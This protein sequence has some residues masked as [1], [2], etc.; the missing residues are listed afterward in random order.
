MKKIFA[1]I[2][3]TLAI[4]NNSMSYDNKTA[5]RDFNTAIV[6]KFKS[7]A[8]EWTEFK[9]YNF[10][11]D[12]V[13]LTG[14]AV[15]ESGYLIV[16]TE[17]RSYTI[18][19]WIKEGGY[20]ADEPEAQAAYRHFYDPVSNDGKTHLTD[21]NMA[22]AQ[23]NPSVDAV[24]WHFMG[25]DVNGNNEWSWHVAKDYMGKA[26]TSSDEKFRNLYLAK[27]LRALGEVLHNTADM[28]CTPHV[29]N[30]AHGGFGLGGSDPYEGGFQPAWIASYAG[31]SCD[32]TL[33]SQFIAAASA[34]EVNR[35]LARFTNKYFFSDETI[36]GNGVETYNSRNGKKDFANPKLDKLAYEAESFNYNYNFPSGRKVQMCNDQSVLL[37]F[38]TS[39]YRSYPRV[40]LKNVE[41]QASE[42][43]PAILEA[44]IHVM[45]HFFPV[46]SV[47]LEIKIQEKI[48]DGT[49]KHTATDEYPN[50]L[51]YNGKVSFLVDGKISTVTASASNGKF[52]VTETDKKFSGA[53]KIIAYIE[54]AD[55]MIKSNEYDFSATTIYNQF[56]FNWMIPAK[57][58]TT[59]LQTNEITNYP[60]GNVAG[61]AISGTISK[62]GNQY[63][64]TWNIS[65][66]NPKKEG[67]IKITVD[68]EKTATVEYTNNFTYS[69]GDYDKITIV[70]KAL[71]F[72]YKTD[73]QIIYETAEA[74]K[75]ASTYSEK[76]KKDNVLWEYTAVEKDIN[77]LT[78]GISLT[79][80]VK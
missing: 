27:A 50:T 79:L 63:T 61:S 20:S 53:K 60:V 76:S 52:S 70:T 69:N 19:E 15:T 13:K 28:G 7:S 1:T 37:G 78:G 9:N 2:I 57:S 66:T 71:P 29:R 68:G 73:G 8:S 72:A 59:N 43:V 34:I 36:S 44:G 55:I 40:T 6:T 35:Q 24:Y 77:N 45:H 51:N 33:K 58:K 49:I 12:L 39:N 26:I 11:F 5:H 47:S 32:A 25:N 18:K 23:F 46:L 67:S 31:N 41:T 21:I 74:F 22:G 17:D 4:I 56:D 62:V 38:L 3:L 42:L 64:G 75:Y 80:Y 65:D 48:I 16:K 10:G 14:P 54:L 30:D